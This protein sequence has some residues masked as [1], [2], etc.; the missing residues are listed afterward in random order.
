MWTQSDPKRKV[1]IM[2]ILAMA[3]FQERYCMWKGKKGHTQP[4]QFITSLEAIQLDC[5]KC[6]TVRNVRSTLSVLERKYE[7]LT[8]ESTK[9]GRLITIENWEKYQG[10][11]IDIDKVYDKWV[12]NDRQT[13]D[14]QVT[15]KEER[16]KEAGKRS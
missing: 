16:K 14:K 1:I 15:T 12:T 10:N 13:G 8:N 11:D 2:T 4:G 3:N 9:E 6:V 5:G 7:F